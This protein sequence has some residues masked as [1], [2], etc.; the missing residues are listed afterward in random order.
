MSKRTSRRKIHGVLFRCGAEGGDLAASC[1][2]ILF[3]RCNSAPIIP[4]RRICHEQFLVAEITMS[5]FKLASTMVEFDPCHRHRRTPPVP[6]RCGAEGCPRRSGHAHNEAHHHI[7]FFLAASLPVTFA[8]SCSLTDIANAVVHSALLLESLDD[9]GAFLGASGWW[10][11]KAAI[12]VTL[13]QS[14]SVTPKAQA[15]IT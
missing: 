7:C 13:A 9:P 10:S 6:K 5:V 8:Q 12:P 4:A 14:C 3:V 11:N 15:W 1:T 2:R